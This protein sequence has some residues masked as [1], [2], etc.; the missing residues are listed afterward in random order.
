MTLKSKDDGF[1]ELWRNPLS[2]RRMLSI[3]GLGAG[4]LAAGALPGCSASAPPSSSGQSGALAVAI[5][6]TFSSLDPATGTAGGTI[7]V[8]NLIYE[9][10]Y[11]VDPYPPR[12]ALSP[13]LAV[14]LPKQ[15]APTT[16]S[17]TLR[18][19]VTF[20]DGGPLSADD[21]VFTLERLKDPKTKSLFARFFLIVK[22]ARAVSA[23]EVQFE[24]TAPTTL[25]P[26]RLALMKIVS[27]NAVSA[28]PDALKLRPAGTGPFRVT[29][30]VSGQQ[31]KL[32][33]STAY[34]GPQKV[35]Y[36]QLE[37]DVISD[38][39]ARLASLRSGQSK[40]VTN[41]PSSSFASISKTPSIEAQG[42]LGNGR[43]GFMF[44]C[45]KPPFNDTRVR[46]AIMYAIDRD[47]ITQ[48]TFFGQAEASWADVV[49]PD[50][51]DY[52]RPRD[53]YRYDPAMAKQLLA[54]AGYG[55][56]GIKVDFLAG[57]SDQLAPQVPIIQQNLQA[58]GFVPNTIPGELE[59]LYTRVSAGTYNLFLFASDPTAL[60][61]ADAEFI[62]RWS[63]Y[64]SVPRT[65]LYWT[66][67]PLTQ[68]ENLL[69]QALTAQD[70]NERAAHLA[71]VQD[72]V[73]SEAPIGFL[74]RLKKATAWSASVSGFR[75]T[76]ANELNLDGVHG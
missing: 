4:A 46:Q 7:A 69:D 11:R 54:A 58:I 39:N 1:D 59:S 41:V 26:E 16:Y 8:N 68:V 61:G 24:L 20:H 15:I 18:D 43:T 5:D 70:P 60:G 30:A 32:A 14:A 49:P 23:R 55:N 13:Q 37:I 67:A 22:S 73:Q 29:G 53:V 17:V 56:G 50:N 36:D 12:S 27:K 63:Y 44:H 6:S 62:L 75:P 28:S 33:K 38:S 65:F 40:I 51:P 9:A 35:S 64:G 74:H 42:V 10:L 21:V 19:A 71:Q 3:A 45:G 57:N 34:N 31:A 52:R 48:S 66:G 25:L 72:I 76:P 2:R 47:A